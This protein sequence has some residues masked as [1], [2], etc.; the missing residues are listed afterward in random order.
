[1]L[2]LAA[3]TTLDDRYEILSVAGSGGMGTVYRAKQIG[4]G[5]EV[6]VKV[7]DPAL[8]GEGDNYERFEREAKSISLAQH[9]HIATFYNF[10]V[11]NS[12]MPYLAMEYLS[13]PSLRQIINDESPLPWQRAFG[14]CAQI[15]E[16]MEA[17]HKAGVIHRDLKPNNVILM[18]RPQ[19][20]FV[21]IVDFGLAKLSTASSGNNKLTVTG[22]LI[23]S[24]N[25]LSPEQCLGR[26]SDERSDIYSLGCIL[27]ELLCGCPPFEHENAVAMLHAHMSETPIKLSKRIDTSKQSK[28]MQVSTTNKQSISGS[29]PGSGE[30]SKQIKK[31]QLE[32]I[33]LNIDAIVSKAMTK[34]PANRYS[35]MREF[36]HDLRAL[37]SGEEDNLIARTGPTLPESPSSDKKKNALAKV[38]GITAATIAIMGGAVFAWLYLSDE[39]QEQRTR[40]TLQGKLNTEDLADLLIKAQTL[41][42]DGKLKLANQ[43]RRSVE[44]NL[45]RAKQDP[46]ELG[47]VYL[48]TTTK[49]LKDGKQKEA[50]QSAFDAIVSTVRLDQQNQKLVNDIALVNQLK[51]ALLVARQTNLS[52]DRAQIKELQFYLSALNSDIIDHKNLADLYDYILENRK[53][54][55]P[56][57]LAAL[58]QSR[59]LAVAHKGSLDE[60]LINELIRSSKVAYGSNSTEAAHNAVSALKT[61]MDYPQRDPKIYSYV[62]K[63][64][65][66]TALSCKGDDS[67]KLNMLF[68]TAQIA[69]NLNYLDEAVR[70]I[71]EIKK[72]LAKDPDYG[73]EHAQLD[74][75]LGRYE[76]ARKNYQ[77][78]ADL[79]SSVI[80]FTYS[81]HSRPF[82]LRLPVLEQAANFEYLGK[83]QAAI[84]VIHTHLRKT[85]EFIDS[86]PDLINAGSTFF[87]DG[88]TNS[89]LQAAEFFSVH[90][91]QDLVLSATKD[92]LR[93]CH[94]YKL[95]GARTLWALRRLIMELDARREWKAAIPYIKEELNIDD[96]FYDVTPETLSLLARSTVYTKLKQLDP[97]LFQQITDK[98]VRTMSTAIQNKRTSGIDLS[99]VIFQLARCEQKEPARKLLKEGLNKL[100]K[101]DPENIALRKNLRA[102]EIAVN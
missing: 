24:V 64:T 21:K 75:L 77:K 23:G 45:K 56:K 48:A 2:T 34:D 82:D 41:Q 90:G 99:S 9:E 50:Q 101:N 60:S 91:H 39:G 38:A 10:G 59:A 67:E 28:D 51:Q 92:A 100:Q 55:T 87:K 52:L 58:A 12:T 84:E 3:G 54:S 69:F 88:L 86:T 42:S 36:E 96:S 93:V 57:E 26:Q 14:I 6:A 73:H 29:M 17:A 71:N 49:F 63:K 22:Q 47:K 81:S 11:L 30:I 79:I 89:W 15:C 94:K 27:Y 74:M 25:Y 32:K 33:W 8:L 68:D 16:G 40:V 37:L 46:L 80:A 19:A 78:S 61:M 20:D 5:R 18:D 65:M 66:D 70:G 95:E 102:L 98:I 97:T 1:M 4:L 62:V 31:K 7:L 35:S 85:E 43:L 44:L 53:A 72:I 13:G 76:H 83:P